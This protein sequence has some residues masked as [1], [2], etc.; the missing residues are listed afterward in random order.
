MRCKGT[1][2]K[3]A[4]YEQEVRHGGPARQV[5]PSGG[6]VPIP[7]GTSLPWGADYALPHPS[8]ERA[9]LRE[10]RLHAQKW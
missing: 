3:I 1:A 8:S 2:K 5:D 10:H 6:P 7:R 4:P 9:M